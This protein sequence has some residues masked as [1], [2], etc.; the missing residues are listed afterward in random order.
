[1]KVT[2]LSVF[3]HLYDDFLKTSLIGRAQQEGAVSF[4][5]A[6]FSDFC[7]PKERLDGPT[8][9]HGTGMAIR[10]EVLERAVEGMEAKYGTAYRI[11]LTPRGKKLNQ[12]KVQELAKLFTQK[13]HIMLVAGRYEGID[14]RAQDHYAD[15]EISIGDYILMGV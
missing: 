11:F 4:D 2:V 9:G 6:G 3:P 15:L 13:E 10:P 5:V 1:M 12:E 8:V 14:A 7:A